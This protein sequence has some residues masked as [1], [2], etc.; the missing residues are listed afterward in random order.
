MNK[1]AQNGKIQHF[2]QT[3]PLTNQEICDM[4]CKNSISFKQ[5]Q[6]NLMTQSYRDYSARNV[7]QL[8]QHKRIVLRLFV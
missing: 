2:R 5:N 7:S 4:L 6:G 3:Y 8:P 1:E